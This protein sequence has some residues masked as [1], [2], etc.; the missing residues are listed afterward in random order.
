MADDLHA[1]YAA[2]TP[3]TLRARIA[4]VP[5]LAGRLG[6]DPAG[7]RAAEVGDGNLNL[8]FIVEG[9]AGAL[10]VKQALP[11]L[12]LVG[13]AWP[14]PL[15]RTFFEW[16]ALTRH[17]AR[18]PGRVPE[19]FHFDEGQA[20]LAMRY[21]TPH[22]I[23]RKAVIDGVIH[24]RM[25][26][27]IGRFMART[28][29]RGSALSLDGTALRREMALFAGNTVLSDITERLVFTDPYF[30]ADGNRHTPG[31]APFIG[32]LRAD[33]ALRVAAQEMKHAFVSRSE[34]L[35]HGDLHSG[36]I[37][38]TADDTRVIDPE[39]AIYGPIGFDVGMFMANLLL[40]YHAQSGHEERPG[41]RDGY[42]AWLLEAV[43]GVWAAFADEF[44]RLW[45]TERTGILYAPALFE[46]AGDP[47]GAEAALARVLRGI[48]VD[49]M[50]FCGVEM[51]RRILGLAHVEDLEAIADPARRA[52]CE[53]R[54]LETGRLLACGR[55]D[56]GPGDVPG[57]AAT[58][59]REIAR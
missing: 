4:A 3:D 29:F 59:E 25:P 24:P 20:L 28:L 41:A 45:R 40:A 55:A 26:G 39:F 43:T 13:E 36:S 21:L 58:I 18:D 23:F 51:H 6:G 54:A 48:L 16:S 44:A 53:A 7:W 52:S 47:A 37:M 38:V 15:R 1:G 35:V 34:T 19:V 10:V 56:I 11:W 30:A 33:R 42:R 5:A 31:L 12:R 8:V 32:P 50:G 9:P 17:G 2:L 22:R 27:D 46:A 49:A 14:L 57:L